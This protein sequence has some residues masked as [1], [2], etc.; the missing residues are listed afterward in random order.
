MK[1]SLIV[2]FAL[3]LIT[4]SVMMT[5]I[6][7]A[8]AGDFAGDFDFGDFGDVDYDYDDSGFGLGLGLLSGLGSGTSV[9]VI[10]I[11]IVIFLIIKFK[12]GSHS[13]GSVPVASGAGAEIT[14]Q[15][16]LLPISDL[17]SEDPAF[18]EADIRE[19]VSNMYIRLQNCWTAKNLEEFRPY[20]TDALYAQ[21]DRQLDS[22]RTNGVTNR[23]ERIAVLS[24]DVRGWKRD[25]ENDT[26]VIA[27]RTRVTDYVV[28][29]ADGTVVRGNPNAEKFMTYEWQLIRARGMKTGEREETVVKNCPN[30]GAPLNINRTAKCDYCGSIITVDQFDWVLSS[31]K[32]ISQQTVGG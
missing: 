30:C 27:L 15:S 3:L 32:A 28:K 9:I 25:N 22:Y 5:V 10:I 23:V 18:S 7:F 12:S 6:S 1:R 13:S 24:A 14:P 4:S 20:S 29:D 2:L 17:I 16:Q 19:K 21:Y 11:I 31:V 8:D 26:L